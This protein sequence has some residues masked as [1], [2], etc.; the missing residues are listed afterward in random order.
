[1]VT[2]PIIDTHVHFWDTD[3]IEYPW[4]QGLP[5]LNRPHTPPDFQRASDGLDIQSVVFVQADAAAERYHDEVEWVTS[6]AAGAP[7]ISGIVSFAPLEEGAPVEAAVEA[8]ASNP[9]VKGIRRLIQSEAV[10]FC[11]R[12][13]FVEGVRLLS[14]FGLSFDLCINHTQLANTI[15]LVR[16]CPDVQFILDHI[17]KP[18]IA[19][20]VLEPWRQHIQSLASLP[21]VVC[22]MSGLVTEAD[23]DNWSLRDLA[24]YI[25]HVIECFG[26]DRVMYGSD[27]PVSTLATDYTRWVTTLS[28]ALEGCSTTEMKKLFHD[29]AVLT[30]R[31]G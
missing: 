29:N 4:L 8:L 30:Y 5:Q 1:M 28:D 21:N 7:P 16:R 11:L 9:L 12:D 18:D 22:K 23:H 6:L 24:P 27:W 31:L 14:R 25:D 2:F 10:D 26:F 13:G 3:R 20:Q 15:E 19:A 17:G